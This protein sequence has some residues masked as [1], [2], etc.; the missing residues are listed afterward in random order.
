MYPNSRLNFESV[1]VNF[2]VFIF[3]IVTVFAKLE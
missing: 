1:T 2:T 3:T